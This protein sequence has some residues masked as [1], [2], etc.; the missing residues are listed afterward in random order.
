[1]IYI[2]KYKM[3]YTY[4]DIYIYHDIYIYNDIYNDIYIMICR[5]GYR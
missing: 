3:I 2:Y 5:Y 1:M 4:N